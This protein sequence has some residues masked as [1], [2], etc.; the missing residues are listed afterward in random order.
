MSRQS[1]SNNPLGKLGYNDCVVCIYYNKNYWR[2]YE[3]YISQCLGDDE[4]KM[5]EEEG[6]KRSECTNRCHKSNYV[7]QQRRMRG[8]K[9]ENKN[10]NPDPTLKYSVTNVVANGWLNIEDDEHPLYWM[11]G[12][13]S[14]SMHVINNKV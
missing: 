7:N 3:Y 1:A 4:T 8:Y 14:L 6:K 12:R 9:K 10:S 2:Y 11:K 13:S 5:V